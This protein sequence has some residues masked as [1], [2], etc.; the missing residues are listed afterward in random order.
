[1]D[2]AMVAEG[3]AFLEPGEVEHNFQERTSD[4]LHCTYCS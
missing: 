4:S 2:A 3:G 1:M